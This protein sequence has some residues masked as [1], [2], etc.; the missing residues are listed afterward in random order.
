MT[1]PPTRANVAKTP[2]RS[3][4]KDGFGPGRRNFPRGGGAQATRHADQSGMTGNISR[5]APIGGIP[6]SGN[7]RSIGWLRGNRAGHGPEKQK[8][9]EIAALSWTSADIGNSNSGSS[10]LDGQG[11]VDLPQYR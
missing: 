9:R 3:N 6:N 11:S 2:A 8:G 7:A 1:G 10:P 5:P 4:K